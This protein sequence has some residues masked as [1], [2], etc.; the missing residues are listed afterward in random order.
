MDMLARG[1]QLPLEYHPTRLGYVPIYSIYVAGEVITFSCFFFSFS[2]QITDVIQ[3]ISNMRKVHFTW[4][5]TS[6]PFKK[7]E[8]EQTRILLQITHSLL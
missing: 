1:E 6:P 2:F 7:E 8:Y 4:F 5:K 3:H